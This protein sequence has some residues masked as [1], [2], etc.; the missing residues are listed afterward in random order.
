VR[1]VIARQVGGSVR[2]IWFV[3]LVTINT[4][5]YLTIYLYVNGGSMKYSELRC[6]FCKEQTDIGKVFE[7]LDINNSEKKCIPVCNT[8][9]DD[10][11]NSTYTYTKTNNRLGFLPDSQKEYISIKRLELQFGVID[12]I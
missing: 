2:V 6:H 7:Y 4:N 10:L 1:F 3:V 9:F 12:T 8:H 5:T 11:C